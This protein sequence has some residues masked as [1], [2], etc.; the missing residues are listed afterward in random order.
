MDKKFVYRKEI[1]AILSWYSITTSILLS[2]DHRGYYFWFIRD[3]T[4]PI[5][6]WFCDSIYFLR[7]KGDL[8]WV[9]INYASGVYLLCNFGL[10]KWDSYNTI[11]I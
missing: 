2:F 9:L 8:I 4:T 7:D 10:C 1:G 5:C 3:A 11:L 6:F